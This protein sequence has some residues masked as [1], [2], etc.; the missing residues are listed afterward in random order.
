MRIQWLGQET[1]PVTIECAKCELWEK[2]TGAVTTGCKCEA[3][4]LKIGGAAV[5]L[6]ALAWLIFK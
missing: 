3:D 2:Q 5:V 6:G 4:P 1:V